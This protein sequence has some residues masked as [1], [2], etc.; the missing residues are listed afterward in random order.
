[1]LILKA[2]EDSR[3]DS[4]TKKR[5]P[6]IIVELEMKLA[7]LARAVSLLFSLIRTFFLILINT[8]LNFIFSVFEKEC[9]FFS[10]LVGSG[11]ISIVISVIKFNEIFLVFQSFYLQDITLRSYSALTQITF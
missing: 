11:K 4:E 9:L 5:E 6:F 2:E 7:N 8:F 3:S 1:M 10:L